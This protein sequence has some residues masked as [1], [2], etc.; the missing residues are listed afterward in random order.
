VS[1]CPLISD[2]MFAAS[3]ASKWATSGHVSAIS[4][5]KEFAGFAAQPVATGFLL[6]LLRAG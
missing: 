6:R 5:Q 2:I 4:Q 1:V 3:R